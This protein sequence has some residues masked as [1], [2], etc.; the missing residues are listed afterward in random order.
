LANFIVLLKILNSFNRTFTFLRFIGALEVNRGR[1]H[2]LNEKRLAT[3]Q[4]TSI[5]FL[6][7][8]GHAFGAKVS[9][10]RT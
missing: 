8:I 7:P 2:L 1:V 9:F 10:A 3:L 4:W 5:L 6:L